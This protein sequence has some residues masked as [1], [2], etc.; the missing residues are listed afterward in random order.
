M[1]GEGGGSR[2]VLKIAYIPGGCCSQ[3][4]DPHCIRIAALAHHITL[5]TLSS[6]GQGKGQQGRQTEGY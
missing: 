4:Q 6:N 3:R 1:S 5:H 2:L